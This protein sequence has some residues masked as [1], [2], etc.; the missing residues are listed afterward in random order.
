VRNAARR[1]GGFP[2]GR[3]KAIRNR[4][5]VVGLVGLALNQWDFSGRRGGTAAH[6]V[7]DVTPPTTPGRF[8]DTSRTHSYTAALI[9]HRASR[10]RNSLRTEE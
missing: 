5:S 6:G 8:V 9:R 4:R 3:R 10:L 7:H 2:A 1:R